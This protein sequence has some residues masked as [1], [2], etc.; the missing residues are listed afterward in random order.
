VKKYIL[1]AAIALISTNSYAGKSESFFK[2]QIDSDWTVYGTSY[3][4]DD[5]KNYQ[6]G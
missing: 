1:A 4:P 2:K 5:E 3:A 6:S